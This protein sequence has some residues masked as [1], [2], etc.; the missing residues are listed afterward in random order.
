[1]V[2]SQERVASIPD[3]SPLECT[4]KSTGLRYQALGLNRNPSGYEASTANHW[5]LVSLSVN[6]KRF[7][8]MG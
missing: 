1:M 8:L 4:A 2:A 3:P 7:Y 5:A 6:E